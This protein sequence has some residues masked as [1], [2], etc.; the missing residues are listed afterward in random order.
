MERRGFLKGLFGGV[1]AGG[2]IVAA[3]PEEIAAFAGGVQPGDAVAV[4]VPSAVDL[5]AGSPLYN[6]KGELVAHVRT[7]NV[8][9][10]MEDVTP[11]G[12]TNTHFIPG[13]VSVVL[14]AEC[15]PTVKYFSGSVGSGFTARVRR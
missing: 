7:I 6:G 1:A 9:R 13:L 3:K 2:L 10:E 4:Q 12:A 14:E 5:Q 8:R 11:R 15:V